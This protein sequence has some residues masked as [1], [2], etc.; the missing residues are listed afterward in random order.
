MAQ[1][2]DFLILNARVRTMDAHDSVAEAV[3]VKEVSGRG[4]ISLR[5]QRNNSMIATLPLQV[6][7]RPPKP[8]GCRGA[9]NSRTLKKP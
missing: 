7:F 1:N 6:L 5:R 2:R 3:L 9:T 8:L 4:P